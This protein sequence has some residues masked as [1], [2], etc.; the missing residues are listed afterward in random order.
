MAPRERRSRRGRRPGRGRRRRAA[1]RRRPTPTSRGRTPR[2]TRR[3]RRRGHRRGQRRRRRRRPDGCRRS[4][5]HRPRPT[6]PGPVAGRPARCAA[7]RGGC[8][9]STTR[10]GRWTARRSPGRRPAR[11]RRTAAGRGC[12]FSGGTPTAAYRSSDHCRSLSSPSRRSSGEVAPGADAAGP[13]VVGH[14]EDPVR[15]RLVRGCRHG[16]AERV[17]RRRDG[18]LVV[19]IGGDERR[20]QPRDEPVVRTRRAAGRAPRRPR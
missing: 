2:A 11:S 17:G 8:A 20:P 18:H 16:R 10:P 15:A 5:G 7:G 6:R 4:P 19:G 1:G 13:I 3:A 9:G 14:H 12:S